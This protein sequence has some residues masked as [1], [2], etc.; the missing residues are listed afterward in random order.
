MIRIADPLTT[1]GA[2]AGLGAL[3]AVGVALMFVFIILGLAIYIY[4]SL[5]LM[6]IAKKTKEG[7]GWFAWV[8]ILNLVLMWKISKTPAWS[9]LLVL[10]AI[11]P[12]VGTFIVLALMIW[13]WWKICERRGHAGWLAILYVIPV[14]NLVIPGL[15]AWV[16]KPIGK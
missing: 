12:I 7:P 14:A 11:I 10:G 16:D 6:T 15:V 8:P 5:A 9:W 1:T 4:T 3:A 2:L 13:W